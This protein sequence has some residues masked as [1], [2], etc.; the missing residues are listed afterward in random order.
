VE[1][2]L[3]FLFHLKIMDDELISTSSLRLWLSSTTAEGPIFIPSPPP[4]GCRILLCGTSPARR[5]AALVRC[6]SVLANAPNA[7]V[8]VL[9]EPDEPSAVAAIR[10][11]AALLPGKASEVRREITT[12][13]PPA[14]VDRRRVAHLLLEIPTLRCEIDAPGGRIALSVLV[15]ALDDDGLGSHNVGCFQRV[16]DGG[17]CCAHRTAVEQWQWASKVGEILAPSARVLLSAQIATTREPGALARERD[18]VLSAMRTAW[19]TAV[20]P[21]ACAVHIVSTASLSDGAST[22]TDTDDDGGGGGGCGDEEP[23]AKQRRVEPRC[24][25]W[26]LTLVAATSEPSGGFVRPPSCPCCS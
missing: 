17:Q 20:H 19:G 9:C 23:L 24:A 10:A 5:S 6:V 1:K 12:Y 21:R 16:W 4:L 14:Y 13:A 2:N 11:A 26:Q 7:A 8:V 22:D 15:C 18:E 25:E 3:F